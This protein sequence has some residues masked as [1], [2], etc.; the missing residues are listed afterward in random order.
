MWIWLRCAL[1]ARQ[2]ERVWQ[3]A[4]SARPASGQGAAWQRTVGW[5]RPRR[6]DVGLQTRQADGDSLQ[7]RARFWAELREGQREAAGR[8]SN[9]DED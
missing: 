8:C 1:A 2:W 4:G 5:P 6:A 3:R 9:R 7:R